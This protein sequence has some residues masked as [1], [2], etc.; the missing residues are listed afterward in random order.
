LGTLDKS[1]AD[2][3]S[4]QSRIVTLQGN[5]SSTLAQINDKIP[6]GQG[7]QVLALSG[8]EQQIIRDFFGVPKGPATQ[9]PKFKVGDAAPDA[10]AIPDD[11]VAKVPQ[12]KGLA[13]AK[14]A[15]NGSV[16]IVALPARRVIAIIAPA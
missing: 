6:Q 1:A 7:V 12:L 13:Y 2:L 4:G 16:L 9:P 5:I 8:G 10:T 14:D 3:A 11:L 15:G